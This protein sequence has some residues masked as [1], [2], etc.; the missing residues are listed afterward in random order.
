[1]ELDQFFCCLV[2]TDISRVIIISLKIY[3]LR[4]FLGY[5]QGYYYFFANLFT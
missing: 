4:G 3:S 5:L 1:M 2:L